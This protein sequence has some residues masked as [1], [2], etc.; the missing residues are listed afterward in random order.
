MSDRITLTGV[1]GIGHHGVFAHERR[2]GQPFVVDVE[3]EADLAG[4]A[5][6]DD[7]ADTVNY[8]EIGAAVLARIEGEPVDLIETLA[9]RIA[10]DVLGHRL[11][12]V[13]TVTVHKPQAP[14]GVEFGDVSVSVTRGR[15]PVPVVIALGANLGHV[16]ETLEAALAAL[17]ACPGLSGVRASRWF[18]T[19]PIGGPDQPAY[20]NLVATALTRWSAP[21]L[22]RALHAIEADHGRVREVRWGARTLDLDLIQYGEPGSPDEWLANGPELTL[23]HPRAHERAFVLVPWHDVAPSASLR[24]GA[25]GAVVTLASVVAD[26]DTSGVRM[27]GPND[28]RGHR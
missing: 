9:A 11:V 24:L 18:E 16:E 4:A 6:S 23:P 13:A 3:I 7:V 25:G 2:D 19:E 1:R 20:L 22:L 10:G 28:G 5:G 27:L 8:G 12:D 15:A 21:R 17:A 26:L 14:V